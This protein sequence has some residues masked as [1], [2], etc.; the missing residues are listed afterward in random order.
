ME[1]GRPSWTAINCAAIRAAHLLLDDDPKILRDDLAM[2]L[3]GFESEGA[4]RLALDERL[5]GVAREFDVEL[6]RFHFDALRALMTVRNRYAEDELT[7]AVER[8]TRQY[9][10]LGAGLDSFAYRKP[11]LRERLRIFEVDYPSTQ[12]WKRKRLS[13]LNVQT[14]RNLTYV[15]VDLETEDAGERLA[16]AGCRFDEPVFVSWLGV[17]QYLEPEST[18]GTLRHIAG[19][20][21]GSEIVFEY[22]VPEDE[23]EGIEREYLRACKARSARQSEPWR[24]LLPS[25]VLMHHLEGMKFAEASDLDAHA[26]NERYFAGRGDDLRVAKAHHLVKARV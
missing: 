8:G 25:A 20:A 22:A 18:L 10:L 1:N 12:A 2:A 26:I 4:L 14:P 19:Y 13:Q 17:T 15:P 16:A 5:S 7:S 6:A 21:P 11:D 3:G 9:V 24:G 23:L